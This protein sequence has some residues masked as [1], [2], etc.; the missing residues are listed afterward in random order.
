MADSLFHSA[1]TLPASVEVPVV[2]DCSCGRAYTARQ[3]DELPTPPGGGLMDMGDGYVVVLRNC[4]CGST[5]GIEVAP[6]APSYCL[7]CEHTHNL[8]VCT[9]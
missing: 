4:A 5:L 2:K 3:F 8:C 1:D 7:A 6:D 9:D